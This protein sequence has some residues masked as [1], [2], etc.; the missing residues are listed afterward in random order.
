MTVDRARGSRDFISKKKM[1]E[2][3]NGN[4]KKARTP[5]PAAVRVSKKEMAPAPGAVRS[6]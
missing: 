6:K 2:V 3:N 4:E 5:V 1:R